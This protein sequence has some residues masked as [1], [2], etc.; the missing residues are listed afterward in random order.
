[1]YHS[2]SFSFDDINMSCNEIGNIK[3]EA[4][5][6]CQEHN[7]EIE[8]VP[9][10]PSYSKGEAYYAIPEDWPRIVVHW[11]ETEPATDEN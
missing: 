3:K 11:T 1:M 7:G 5:T 6:F 8:Y 10:R 4:E 9:G 2:K